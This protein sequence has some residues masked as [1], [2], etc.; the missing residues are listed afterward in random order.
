MAGKQGEDFLM[1]TAVVA[2]VSFLLV[3]AL[4]PAEY[5]NLAFLYLVLEATLLWVIGMFEQGS[6]STVATNARL[7]ATYIA[8]AALLSDG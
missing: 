2:M 5:Q 1:K 4:L 6:G 7:L 8:L 3:E